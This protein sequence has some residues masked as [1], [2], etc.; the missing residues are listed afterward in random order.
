MRKYLQYIILAVSLMVISA[1]QAQDLHFSQYFNAPLLVNPANTGFNPD[2]DYRVGGNYRNQ[3]AGVLNNPYKT[4][5]LWG[6]AQLFNNRFENGWVG[7]G[8]TLYRDEA[9]TG[10]LTSTQGYV[11]AAYHQMLGYSSLLSFGAN[12]GFVNKRIDISKLSFDNQW[13]GKFFDINAG[14]GESFVYSGVGYFDLQVGLNYALF[15]SSKAY[16]NLGVSAAHINRPQESFFAPSSTVDTRVPIR[17]TTFLNGSFKID[18]NWIVNPNIYVSQ[19][20]N[21][22]ETV[23]GINANRNLSGDGGAQQLIIGA[24]YRNADAIIPMIGYQQ[25][26]IKITFNYD[27]TT[28]NLGSFNG[29][30]GAYEISIVKSGVYGGNGKAIKCPTVKF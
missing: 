24:Y 28:S 29:R 27:A 14:S 20:T 3:W 4:M 6:D 18:D 16:F 30:Q 26:D 19:S 11:S 5:S 25:D 21:S 22:T 12:I 1:L 10:S 7:L 8:G 15:L 23:I 2:Y 17:F 13:N 9:G